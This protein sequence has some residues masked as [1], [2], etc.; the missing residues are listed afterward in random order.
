MDDGPS[1]YAI[2]MAINVAS[3]NG[4]Y[5]I[6]HLLI[7]DPRIY[8]TDINCAIRLAYKS[9]H[10]NIVKELCFRKRIFGEIIEEIEW[11]N[12]RI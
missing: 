8:L 4:H 12:N 10:S 5:E 2:D 1:D 9:G 3:I 6:V 7:S 11:L